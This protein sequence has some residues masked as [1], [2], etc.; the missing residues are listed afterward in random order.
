MTPTG[1]R[2]GLPR[3]VGI[4]VVTLCSALTVRCATAQQRPPRATPEPP[5]TGEAD[6]VP[7]S[8]V[9]EHVRSLSFYTWRGAIGEQRLHVRSAGGQWTVGPLA[10]I[11]PEIGS[12]ALDPANLGGKGRIVAHI[13]SDGD[14][15][16]LGIKAGD[17]YVWVD[18]AGTRAA[19]IPAD[20]NSAPTTLKL[21]VLETHRPNEKPAS[22]R[23]LWSD[24]DEVA[25]MTCPW[26]CCKVQQ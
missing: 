5:F 24:T 7:R 26:G 11:E 22:A 10:R 21:T 8:A 6:A 25:W 14:Y 4:A 3:M 12:A 17:N 1:E 16:K 19:M 20:P 9:L 15:A 23:W 2:G 18:H 13:W